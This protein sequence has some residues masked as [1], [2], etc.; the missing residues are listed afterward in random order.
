MSAHTSQLITA[1]E[2]DRDGDWDGAHNIVQRLDAMDANWIHAYLHRKE[3]VM[4]NA[5][6]WYRRVDKAVPDYSLAQEW[7]E[8]YDFVIRERKV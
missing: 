3:G 6:Y 2:L 4:W 1:L 8:L 7:R 5:H